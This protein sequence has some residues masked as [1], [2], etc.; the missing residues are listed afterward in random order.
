MPVYDRVDAVVRLATTNPFSASGRGMSQG[1]Y[2]YTNELP[3]SENERERKTDREPHEPGVTVLPSFNPHPQEPDTGRRQRR[4]DGREDPPAVPSSRRRRDSPASPTP[5][6]RRTRDAPA[7]RQTFREPSP[8]SRPVYA[9]HLDSD[10]EYQ[11][12]QARPGARSSR[13]A[14][15][16]SLGRAST[17]TRQ[18]LPVPQ[19]PEHSDE[20]IYPSASKAKD[21]SVSALVCNEWV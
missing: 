4:R 8:Q 18:P 1:E 17:A 16:A 11:I 20:E 9:E 3:Q 2:C 13:L 7:R 21:G 12:P 15:Q 14:K 6:R 10:E 19:Y 5:V